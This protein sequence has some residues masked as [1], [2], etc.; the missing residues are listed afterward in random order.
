MLEYLAL[1][2]HRRGSQTKIDGQNGVRVIARIR[3]VIARC[4]LQGP[5]KRRQD[6]QNLEILKYDKITESVY[7]FE[8]G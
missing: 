2:N 6:L 1:L 4:H 8:P 3:D 5:P 7:L